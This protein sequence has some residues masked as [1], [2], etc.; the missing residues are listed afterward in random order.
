MGLKDVGNGTCTGTGYGISVMDRFPC[1]ADDTNDHRNAQSD[2]VSTCD[3]TAVH[4]A[5]P[6]PPGGGGGGGGCAMV[7]L[8]IG[9]A[10]PQACTGGGPPPDPSGDWPPSP[11]I[12]DVGGD[13]FDL[14]AAEDGVAFDL[15]P[16]GSPEQLAWTVTDTNDGWL[17]LDR[18]GNGVIDDGTELF[19]NF[20][21]QAPSD[22]KNGFAALAV[23][24]D[25]DQGGNGDGVISGDDAI[26]EA[27]RIWLDANHDGISEP[28][29]LFRLEDVG[30]EGISLEYATSRRR[31]AH[32]NEFRFR[33]R[34][35]AA[36]HA[37][38]GRFAFD[39]FLTTVP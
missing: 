2:S 36:P 17:A 14:S 18:N 33:A 34:V 11:I 29:E 28:G 1:V 21:P 32:G 12:L 9:I 7:A 6:A 23:F 22:T 16:G 37:H 30:I 8:G 26:F 38:V 10:A 31:D 27:L 4:N 39:V 5:F 20:T 3:N 24:D 25:P 15:Q 35:F 13:G 19:G